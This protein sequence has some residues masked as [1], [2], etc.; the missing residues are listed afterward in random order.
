[1]NW[2]KFIAGFLHTAF[3][4]KIYNKGRRLYLM[5]MCANKLDLSSI[6]LIPVGGLP[7][8]HQFAAAAWTYDVV[9]VVLAADRKS[10]GSFGKL[11][12]IC[13][14]FVYTFHCALALSS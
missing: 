13:S 2:C 4:K 9:K 12:A 10:D 7:P 14:S 6:N 1:M 8:P 5:L 11:Q 3:S